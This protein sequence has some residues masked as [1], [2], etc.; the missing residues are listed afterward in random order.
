MIYKNNFQENINQMSELSTKDKTY[1]ILYDKNVKP[2]HKKSYFNFNSALSNFSKGIF[3]KCYLEI[4]CKDNKINYE[5]ITF[6]KNNIK[7]SDKKFE[8]FISDISYLKIEE[9]RNENDKIMLKNL[10]KLFDFFEELKLRISAEYQGEESLNFE[11]NLTNNINND[12]NN[13]NIFNIDAFYKFNDTKNKSISTYKDKNILINRTNSLEQGF[14]YMILNINSKRKKKEYV[15][16]NNNL[17][18]EEKKEQNEAN[19]NN[20]EDGYKASSFLEVPN[21]KNK[22]SEMAILEIIKIIEK[23]SSYNGFIKE[24]S[25]GYFAYMKSDNHL[26]IIDPEFNHIM[27]INDYGERIVY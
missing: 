6:G 11:I 3:E 16:Q 5:N 4:S 26:V 14:N 18:N 15:E 12:N 7:L 1:D 21:I 19:E 20:K 9:L 2:I 10:L 13:N 24:L 23:I 22:P 25:N 8:Q 27:D 17:K